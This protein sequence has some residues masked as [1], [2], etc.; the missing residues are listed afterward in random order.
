MDGAKRLVWG[1]RNIRLITRANNTRQ[2]NLSG[3]LLSL[4]GAAILYWLTDLYY[5]RAFGQVT[6]TP[7]QARKDAVVSITFSILA[8]WSFVLDTAEILPINMPGV[9][10][11]AALAMDFWQ[12]TRSVMG[13]AITSFPESFFASLIIF[14]V[15]LLP[16]FGIT[17]WK[18]FGFNA[19]LEAMLAFDG[20]VLM[21]AGIAGHIRLTRDL[22]AGEA[23]QNDIAL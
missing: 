1:N 13:E 5:T 15:S 6:P 9:V 23:K 20:L 11:A 10:L 4:I 16:L 19:Q 2:G 12:S 21:L 7:A 18:V 14:I 17:W 8:I 22:A 3:P